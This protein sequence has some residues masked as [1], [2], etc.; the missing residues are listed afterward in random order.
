LIKTAMGDYHL[1]YTW[2]R[3]RIAYVYFNQ[4]WLEQQP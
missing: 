3:K 2:Q 4:S 1:V